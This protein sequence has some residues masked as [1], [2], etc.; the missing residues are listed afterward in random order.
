VTLHEVVNGNTEA[1]YL[2][3]AVTS[4]PQESSLSATTRGMEAKL[5]IS[6]GAKRSQ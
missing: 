1:I 2:I 6:W 4:F 5:Y 3:S